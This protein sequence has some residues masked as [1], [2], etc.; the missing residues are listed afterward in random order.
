MFEKS[1]GKRVKVPVDPIPEADTW[2]PDGALASGVQ[3]CGLRTSRVRVYCPL[4]GCQNGNP[5]YNRRRPGRQNGNPW[6]THHDQL[7][8]GAPERRP[9]MIQAANTRMPPL[10]TPSMFAC[11]RLLSAALSHGIDSQ[12]QGAPATVILGGVLLGPAVILMFVRVV[13]MKEQHRPQIR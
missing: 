8:V 12:A 2:L 13:L 4:L 3:N 10:L 6:L 1:Y 7:R 5:G 11:T 9:A